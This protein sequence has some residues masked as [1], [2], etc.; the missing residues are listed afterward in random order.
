MD[1]V[2]ASAIGKLGTGKL[3]AKLVRTGLE[4]DESLEVGAANWPA[5]WREAVVESRNG[6]VSIECLLGWIGNRS[7]DDENLLVNL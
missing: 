5:D 2:G 7:V 1:W 6:D 3:E 4:I